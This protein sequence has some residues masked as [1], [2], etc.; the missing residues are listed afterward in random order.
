MRLRF[1]CR[2]VLDVDK[3]ERQ[4]PEDGHTDTKY[5]GAGPLGCLC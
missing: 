3:A 5:V 2:G 1:G 4:L